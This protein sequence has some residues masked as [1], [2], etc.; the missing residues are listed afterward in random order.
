MGFVDV[1]AVAI[2]AWIFTERPKD[3]G[4]VHLGIWRRS[5]TILN[6]LIDE[7]S[8]ADDGFSRRLPLL[9]VPHQLPREIFPRSNYIKLARLRLGRAA[10]SPSAIVIT[11]TSA[12]VA[13]DSTQLVALRDLV[14]GIA[15]GRGDSCVCGDS[16][17]WRDRLWIWPVS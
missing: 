6:R 2:C 9:T 1:S 8:S 17:D 11:G 4:G 15:A 7:L 3:Y 12:S 16:D 13:L 5:V 10:S 14:A